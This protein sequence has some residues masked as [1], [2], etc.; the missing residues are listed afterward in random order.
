MVVLH[1]PCQVREVGVFDVSNAGPLPAWEQADE[2]LVAVRATS[3]V[4]Q[5]Q[6]LEM[7][8]A[9]TAL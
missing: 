1:R 4:T 8:I 9:G 6:V 2:R 7:I 5:E 3:E